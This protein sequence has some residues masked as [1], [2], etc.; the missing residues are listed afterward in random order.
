MSVTTLHPATDPHTVQ[1]DGLRRRA[2]SLRTQAG[3]LSPVLANAYRRRASE[4]EL[5]AFLVALQSEDAEI[6]GVPAA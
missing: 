3:G 1:A 6:K 5:E 4:L 2:R